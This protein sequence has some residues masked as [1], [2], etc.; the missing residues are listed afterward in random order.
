M[1]NGTA[2]IVAGGQGDG[3]ALSTVEVMDTETHQW[4]TAADLP[5][6]IYWVSATVCGDQLCM[7]GGVEDCL[8]VKSAYTCS[9]NAL[10]QSCVPS[11]L[12]AKIQRTSL[13]DKTRV[14]RQIADV[15]IIRSTCESFHGRLLAVGGLESGK[16]TAAVY[17]YNSTTN[18]WEITS[19]M[20]TGRSDCFT[21]VLPDNRLMVVGGYIDHAC[22]HH[23]L[24][25]SSYCVMTIE[26]KLL[27][28]V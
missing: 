21:V 18:F 27:L 7:V 12:E 10:L 20:T 24:S 25:R 8:Y 6:P 15:P 26:Y 11:S 14:W 17:M 1:C 9:V 5:Q 28:L 19:H 3:R 4:S 13:K 2:L 16:V 22:F 23:Q